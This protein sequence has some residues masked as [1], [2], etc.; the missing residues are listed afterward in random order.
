MDTTDESFSP[1]IVTNGGEFVRALRFFAYLLLYLV[2][3]ISCELY[4]GTLMCDVSKTIMHFL[5]VNTEERQFKCGLK[6]SF[7][8]GA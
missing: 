8:S 6:C 4:E 7:R 5:M 1:V 2:L 3:L